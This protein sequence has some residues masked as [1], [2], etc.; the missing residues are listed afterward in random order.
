[1]PKSNQFDMSRD[2][3][4]CQ[5]FK[6]KVRASE[7]YAQNLYAA[8]CNTQW[9]PAEIWPVL[10]NEYWSCSWR[11]A[12]GIVAD[13]RACGEDYMDYYCSGMGG[14]SALDSETDEEAQAHFKSKGF[15]PEE[16]ITDEIRNDLAQLG[17]YPVIIPRTV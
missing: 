7:S 9:Q 14:F 1:M 12:G 2:M 11:S 10:K 15:V 16:E 13:L 8:M 17:W 4:D 3:Q 5:W 6:D